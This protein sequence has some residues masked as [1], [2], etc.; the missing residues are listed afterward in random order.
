[1]ADA[2][3]LFHPMKIAA[4]KRAGIGICL[5]MPFTGCNIRGTCGTTLANSFTR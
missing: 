3:R 1:L 5:A 2:A 4:K